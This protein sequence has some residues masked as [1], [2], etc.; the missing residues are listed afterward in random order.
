MRK[1]FVSYNAGLIDSDFRGTVLILI[2]NNSMELLVIK[3]DQRIAQI[4][5]RKK[6]VVFEKV[7]CLSSTERVF[8][9]FG[10]TGI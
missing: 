10:S 6:E 2:T 1:Y 5:L 8:G 7:N 9:G 3:A 4:V